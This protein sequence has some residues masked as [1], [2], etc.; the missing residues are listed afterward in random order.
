MQSRGRVLGTASPGM[1]KELCLH[2]PIIRWPFS[3]GLCVRRDANQTGVWL[4]SALWGAIA[5]VFFVLPIVRWASGSYET[6]CIYLYGT[7]KIAQK[8]P[9]N[10]VFA[11]LSRDW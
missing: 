5:M 8:L 9:Q 10:V 4:L 6:V 11:S 2:D 7:W 1:E 3:C